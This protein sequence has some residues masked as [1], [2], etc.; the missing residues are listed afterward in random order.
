MA[1][2]ASSSLQNL[3]RRIAF[4]FTRY[5]TV[6]LHELGHATAVWLTCGRVTGMEVHPNEGGVTKYIG[7]IALIVLPAVRLQRKNA[8]AIGLLGFCRVG[9]GSRHREC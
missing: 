7:G 9:H 4:I 1:N 2:R 5:R 3:V 6:F 8:Y